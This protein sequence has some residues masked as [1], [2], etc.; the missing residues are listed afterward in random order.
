MS[1]L[2]SSVERVQSVFLYKILGLPHCVPYAALC[3]EGGQQRIETRAWLRFLKY[4]VK[5]C[6]FSSKDILLQALLADSLLPKGLALFLKKIKTLGLSPDSMGSIPPPRVFQTIKNRVLDIE[7]QTLFSAALKVCSPLHFQLPLTLGRRPSYLHHLEQPQ[8]RWAFTLARCN[9]VPSS[10]AQGR[11]KGLPTELRVC[12]C[13]QGKTE[14]LQ[15]MLFYCTLYKD[16]RLSHLTVF[17]PSHSGWADLRK[18]QYLLCDLSKEVTLSTARYVQAIIQ[19]RRNMLPQ[20]E[21][22]QLRFP[23]TSS[24]L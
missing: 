18:I 2:H 21:G 12:P 6:F 3:L 11:Y 1:S 10:L 22:L 15:H 16:I 7:G 17:L 13:G 9:I 23:G 8:D 14:S 4:W 5:I 24:C 19:R 20:N